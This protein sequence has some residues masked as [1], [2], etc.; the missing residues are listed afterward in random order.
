MLPHCDTLED[1]DKMIDKVTKGGKKTNKP[2]VQLPRGGEFKALPQCLL[3]SRNGKCGV[4]VHTVLSNQAVLTCTR[5]AQTCLPLA[6]LSGSQLLGHVYAVTLENTLGR[7]P[8]G[9]HS[10]TTRYLQKPT[11]AWARCIH[12]QEGSKVISPGT[13]NLWLWRAHSFHGLKKKKGMHVFLQVFWGSKLKLINNH[14]IIN[15]SS[16][17]TQIW[18]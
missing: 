18:P 1:K 10:P 13:F 17:A 11:P 3:W 2:L 14:V 7:S 8:A 6:R 4:G 16:H 12:R 5:N 15:V 9:R